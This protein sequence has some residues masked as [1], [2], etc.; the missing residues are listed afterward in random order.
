MTRGSVPRVN[1][2]MH[3]GEYV[4][5]DKAVIIRPQAPPPGRQTLKGSALRWGPQLLSQLPPP[6]GTSPRLGEH[7]PPAGGNQKNGAAE[8]CTPHKTSFPGGNANTFQPSYKPYK[9]SYKPSYKPCTAPR[10]FVQTAQT[11][12]QGAYFPTPQFVTVCTVCTNSLSAVHGLYD[13]LYDVL[14]G[15]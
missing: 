4:C 2:N 9:P 11:V 6:N 5:F 13:G 8:N 1:D 7:M 10:E 3:A 15:L 14:Y 12:H